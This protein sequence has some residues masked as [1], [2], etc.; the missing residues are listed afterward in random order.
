MI[1]NAVIGVDLGG[2]AIKYGLINEDKEILWSASKPSKASVSASEV[3]DNILDSIQEAVKKSKE[4]ELGVVSIGLGTPGL[5]EKSNIVV[6]GANN[7]KG[8]SNIP[9]G[10]ILSIRTGIKTFIANDADMMGLG[11]FTLAPNYQHDS[12][13]FITLGTGIGGAIFINGELFNGHYG[14]GGE[15]GLLPIVVDGQRSYWEDIASTSAMV[16]EYEKVALKAS[17]NIN[18]E[19]IVDKYFKKD[20]IAIEIIDR[21]TQYIGVGLAGY[22]NIFNPKRIIIGGGVSQAGSFFID[23]IKRYTKENALKES[24]NGV[25]IQ[26]AKL[27]NKAGFFGAGLFAFKKI[28]TKDEK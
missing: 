1:K 15:L 5:V 7:I 11:E 23:K 17:D 6:G 26:V 16:R 2:T 10:K 21:I 24:Y 4:L 18:G 25:D 13:L 14:L 27:G 9:L 28:Q 12:M 19:Y 8:W 3:V 22:V 20:P